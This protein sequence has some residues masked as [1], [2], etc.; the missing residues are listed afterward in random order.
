GDLGRWRA[1]GTIEFL[2]R[3]DFQ[4]KIRGFR[5][6]LGEIEA[7]LLEYPGIEQVAVVARED[8]PGDKRLV[9]YYTGRPEAGAEALR[10]HLL[11]RLPEYMVPAAYV[12]L[13]QLPLTPNGKLDRRALPAPDVSAVVTHAYEAPQGEVEQVLAE[14]W[15]QLLQVERV[16]RQDHFFEL[17]GHSLLAVQLISRLRQV[18]GLEVALADLFARPV[19]AD[20]AQALES[21]ARVQLPPITVSE[22]GEPLPLSFAQQR[23]WFLAQMPGVSEAYHI[24]GGLRLTGELGRSALRRALDRLVA[25]HEALRTT[26]P[27]LDGQPIARIASEASGF[28]LRE[29]DL[30][31]HAA[32]AQALGGLV[33]EE[34]RVPFDLAKGPLIRGRLIQ[35]AEEEHVLLLTMHHIVSDGWSMGVLVRELGALYSAFRRGEMD[36]LPALSIQYADYAVW[37][38]RWLTGERLEAQSEYW[39]RTLAGAPTVLELPRD[40]A[41]PA[42]QDHAGASVEVVLEENL[43]CG[44]KALSRRHGTTLFMTL[45]SSWAVLL[46]RLS[47]QEEVLIGTP[48]ANRR[49]VEIEGLIGFFVNTLAL[50]LDVVGAATVGELLERVKEQVLGAQQHQD[51]PFEQVVEIV[52]PSRSLAH[53]PLFQVMFAWQNASGDTLALPGLM[54]APLAAPPV[55]AK[56]DLTLSLGEAGPAIVGGLE[57]ATALFERST[58]ERYLG[59]WRR[60]LEGM[61]ADDQQAVDR[62]P[63]LGAGERQQVVVEW[64]AT[65]VEYERD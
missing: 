25:R 54:L 34:A 6:E 21:A 53:S 58:I 31:S 64:N 46:A 28:A 42:Q 37:Q 22:R 47:G 16:G 40:Y 32:A 30:R 9:A 17:G 60:L 20:L 44:L 51:L 24:A 1:D 38:R 13:E 29:Y 41:R 14:I 33:A 65:A 36:P 62:L 35:L 63:M 12:E 26:F 50:R 10:A 56:F 11:A 23:L 27:V 39:R 61:V 57:Y 49:R 7:R 19:L 2:G 55:A 18:L 15:Q 5:I 52:R 45:L 48:V 59:Y 43:T 4:V 8:A 3:T